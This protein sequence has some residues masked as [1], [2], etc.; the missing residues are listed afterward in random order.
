[1]ENDLS[2]VSEATVV[3]KED[4]NLSSRSES[5][6]VCVYSIHSG[7]HSEE[8]LQKYVYDKQK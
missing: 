7:K 1:M 3:Q 4:K 6:Q 8:Y 2:S 5:F